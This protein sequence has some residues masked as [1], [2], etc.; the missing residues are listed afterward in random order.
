[1][2][3]S[4]LAKVDLPLPLTPRR[5]FLSP[6]VAPPAFFESDG[7]HLNADAGASFIFYLVAGSDQLFPPTPESTNVTT[8]V[9]SQMVTSSLASLSRSV[10]ELRSDVR[11]RRLQDN[12]IFARIKEDRDYEI[13][14]S[15]KDRTTSGICYK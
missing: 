12:L 13:N 14:K 1:M 11:R 9:S 2:L 6:F 15:R 8:D 5:K 3:T 7:V 10:S 4:D